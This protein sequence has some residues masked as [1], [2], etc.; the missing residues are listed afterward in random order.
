MGHAEGFPLLSL[1]LAI[2][3][4]VATSAANAG[5]ELTS[6]AR[7]A[8]RRL[9]RRASR[10][11]THLAHAARD[12]EKLFGILLELSG[13]TVS[14]VRLRVLLRRVVTEPPSWARSTLGGD[15]SAVLAWLAS[16]ARCRAR[17]GLVLARFA[18]F[19]GISTSRI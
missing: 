14:A 19:A 17:A 8:L 1:V 13:G 18:G 4:V 12:A 6:R 10:R 15:G 9:Q 16:D 3:T 5:L 7:D 11:V 2:D